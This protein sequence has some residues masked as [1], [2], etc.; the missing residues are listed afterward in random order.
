MFAPMF[1]IFEDPATGSAAGPFGCYLV[2]NGLAQG[3]NI[4]CEQ[5]FEMGRPGILKVNIELNGEE[6]TAVKVS[7]DIVSTGKGEMYID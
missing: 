5:G 6:I 4:I 7:G 3:K 1:C 2:K